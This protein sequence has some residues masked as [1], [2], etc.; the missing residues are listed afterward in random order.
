MSAVDGLG[1][2]LVEGDSRYMSAELLQDGPKDLTKCDV[3]SLGATV[4]EMCR[5]FPLPPNGPEWHAVRSGQPPPIDFGAVDPANDLM[6]VLTQM[7]ARE[8]SQRPSA[9]VLLTHPRL[10]SR[11]ER[12]LLREKNKTKHLAKALVQNQQQQSKGRKL[13]RTQTY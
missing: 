11:L 5:G 7:M 1:D 3:F 2:C 9:A 13:E 10:R 12:E 6:R 4:Y 8:P